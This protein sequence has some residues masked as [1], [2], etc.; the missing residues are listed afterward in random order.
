MELKCVQTIAHKCDAET[1]TRT[2]SLLV[3]QPGN[4][5]VLRDGIGALEV[6]EMEAVSFPGHLEDLH[7]PGPPAGPEPVPV[8]AAAVA[9]H[10]LLRDAHE[11]A[12]ARHRVQRRRAVGERVDPGVVD[13]RGARAHHPPHG[14][15]V[16]RHGRVVVLGGHLAVAQEVGVDQR[17]AADPD[18]AGEAALGAHRHVVRD[19]GAGALAGEAEA[20]EIAVVGEPGLVAGSGRRVGGDPDERLPGVLVRG[21]DRVLRR[22]AVVDGDDDCAGARGEGGE[23]PVED[24]VEGGVQAE[25]AAVEVYEDRKLLLLA[26]VVVIPRPF[27]RRRE[28]DADGY[29]GGYGAVLGGDARSG[30]RGGWDGVRA[31]E[32][33]HAAALEDADAVLHLEGDLVVAGAGSGHGRSQTRGTCN[34]F[35]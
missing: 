12:V 22:E 9:D 21:G 4:G 24:E 19:V 10:V 31:E 29:V 25:A 33:L 2:R 20:G 35:A 7:L 16:R 13:A 30:V 1:A 11:H 15:H 34:E 23:V 18:A 8:R 32:A 17:D 5:V 3:N 14:H 28:V 27:G 6:N 26:G